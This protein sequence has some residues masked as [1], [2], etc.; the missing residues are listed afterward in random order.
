MPRQ[1]RILL[2]DDDPLLI[3]SVKEILQG[4]GHA[5]VAADG[6]QN[7]I[8]TFHAALANGSPFS[9]WITHLGLPYL[10]GHKVASAVKAPPLYTPVILLTPRPP[11]LPPNNHN[12]PPLTPP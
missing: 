3:D 10:D 8:E 7:G 4:D 2:V 11:P 6:G 12:P 1:V 9:L 5:V